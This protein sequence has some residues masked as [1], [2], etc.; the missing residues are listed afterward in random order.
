MPPC[1]IALRHGPLYLVRTDSSADPLYLD[2]L[3][4]VMARLGTVAK[5]RRLNNM[6]ALGNSRV[7]LR[8]SIDC[9]GRGVVLI[10]VLVHILLFA[11]TGS[12]CWL[13]YRSL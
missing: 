5:L 13:N 7:K 9:L 2:G 10:L 11:T 8:M 1:L 6:L 12:P 3:Y 4:T